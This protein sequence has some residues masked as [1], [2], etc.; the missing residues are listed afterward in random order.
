MHTRGIYV[1]NYDAPGPLSYRAISQ[2]REQSDEEKRTHMHT[3]FPRRSS[4]QSVGFFILYFSYFSHIA[5]AVRWPFAVSE[6]QRLSAQLPAAS[7]VNKSSTLCTEVLKRD[8]N[9]IA[10]DRLFLAGKVQLSPNLKLFQNV[11]F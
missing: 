5:L 3:T 2:R 9:L 4:G 1:K 10:I 6:T 8:K 11:P 7:I